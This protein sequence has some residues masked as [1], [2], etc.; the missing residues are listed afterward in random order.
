MVGVGELITVG[1]V[2]VGAA[3]T[4]EAEVV[5]AG[6]VGVGAGETLGLGFETTTGPEEGAGGV[7]GVET[8]PEAEVTGVGAGVGV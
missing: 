2:G 6:A 7:G 5:G 3:T 8:T 4:P 1:V